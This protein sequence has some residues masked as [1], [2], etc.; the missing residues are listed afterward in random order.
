MANLKT[1]TGFV[2]VKFHAGRIEGKPNENLELGF[3][4]EKQAGIHSCLNS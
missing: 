3:R 1:E 2:E 4:C